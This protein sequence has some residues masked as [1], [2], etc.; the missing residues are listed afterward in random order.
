M[1]PCSCRVL[2]H[3]I[4]RLLIASVFYALLSLAGGRC[5]RPRFCALPRSS[6]SRDSSQRSASR[7]SSSHRSSARSRSASRDSLS[8]QSSARSRSSS[9]ESSSQQS[10]AR[11]RSASRESS[12]HRSSAQPRTRRAWPLAGSQRGRQLLSSVAGPSAQPDSSLPVVPSIAADAT[13]EKDAIPGE[14][15][16]DESDNDSDSSGRGINYDLD[17]SDDEYDG[18]THGSSDDFPGLADEVNQSLPVEDGS[19]PQSRSPSPWYVPD[20]QMMPYDTPPRDSSS[21]REFGLLHRHSV[22][23]SSNSSVA[24]YNAVPPPSNDGSPTNAVSVS[25][26]PPNTPPPTPGILRRTRRVARRLQRRVAA[27]IE[28]VSLRL[29]R[30]PSSSGS[31]E[32]Q[33]KSSPSSLRTTSHTPS[34]ERPHDSL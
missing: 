26:S 3:T 20:G 10:S 5:L 8:Q 11:S 25:S 23:S 4:H 22:N 31:V 9:R 13:R 1:Q 16:I 33:S 24:S 34:P 21:S 27:Q 32:E 12:S 28:R 17:R 6:M 15:D 2:I 19:P 18:R 14:R 29:G 7:D 30:P